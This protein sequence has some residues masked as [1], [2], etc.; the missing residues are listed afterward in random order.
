MADV[1]SSD[2]LH[3]QI[4]DWAHEK[5]RT[6]SAKDPEGRSPDDRWSTT[7]AKLGF[8]G[9]ILTGSVI[10]G[11]ESLVGT[12]RTIQARSL[13]S[14]TEEAEDAWEKADLALQ[15]VFEGLTGLVDSKAILTQADK[16]KIAAINL[17]GQQLTTLN[18]IPP[19]VRQQLVKNL[20][21]AQV[22]VK[23]GKAEEKD[24]SNLFNL[25]NTV[26]AEKPEAV[27]EKLKSMKWTKQ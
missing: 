13:G 4:L 14:G 11:W 1:H 18:D 26:K 17:Y 8:V 21:N 27:S 10:A 3:K 7:Q 22:M 5:V 24:V 23:T 2:T 15:T 20:R 16:R 12:G 19:E 9:A 25:L 6:A